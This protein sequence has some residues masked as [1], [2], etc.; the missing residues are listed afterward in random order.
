MQDIFGVLGA[1]H[2][3][4]D[5]SKTERGAKIYATRNGYDKVYCRSNSG[6]HV[7]LVAVKYQGKWFHPEALPAIN[8]EVITDVIDPTDLSLYDN[9]GGYSS[10]LV[11]VT[12]DGGT[13]A[14]STVQEELKADRAL[15]SDSSDPQWF[16]VDSF[17]NWE[18]Q[19]LTDSHTN[20]PIPSCYG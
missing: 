7:F 10:C 5:V 8:N 4:I 16:I 6:Y 2:G 14:L 9:T 19:D 18:D 11:F 3:V 20:K 17:V 1:D 13:L 15:F 12:K